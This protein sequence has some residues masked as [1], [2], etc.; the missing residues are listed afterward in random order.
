MRVKHGTKMRCSVIGDGRVVDVSEDIP[1][2]TM[3]GHETTTSIMFNALTMSGGIRWRHPRTGENY[4]RVQLQWEL[5]NPED[6]LHGD[7]LCD[8]ADCIRPQEAGLV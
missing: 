8:C 1:I 5:M 7:E 4:R 3:G 2:E 6:E